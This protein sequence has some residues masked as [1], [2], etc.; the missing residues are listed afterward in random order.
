MDEI[1][2]S[3]KNP[4]TKNNTLFVLCS[5]IIFALISALAFVL[6]HG[7]ILRTVL[8]GFAYGLTYWL[9]FGIVSRLPIIQTREL[10]R[11]SLKNPIRQIRNNLDVVTGIALSAGLFF[12][13]TFGPGFTIVGFI[14]GI[15]VF[16]LEIILLDLIHNSADFIQVNTPYQ[17]FISSA[18]NLYFSI[19][20]HLLLRYQLYKQGLLPL[21][22]VTFLNELSLRHILE[23]DGDPTTGKGGGAWRFR[24]RILQEWFAEKWVEPEDPNK[25]K[26]E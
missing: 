20:Q 10:K 3:W 11:W 1:H 19:L 23:F 24:H 16:G 13:L 14:F 4:L 15:M 5:M 17:R 8:Y 9:I 2:W 21:K 18:K 22:L 26:T 6:S 12:G 7:I 25:L